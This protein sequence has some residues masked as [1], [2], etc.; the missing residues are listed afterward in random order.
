MTSN[1]ERV[2]HLTLHK[3][4]FD[5]IASGEKPEEYRELKAYWFKRL[6]Y[7][8]EFRKFEY[9]V[10]T[11]GYATDAPRIVVECKGISI[12]EGRSEWGAISG[13]RY[14]VIKL[15]EILPNY[16]MIGEKLT[17]VV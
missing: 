2:L 4:Y 8:G 6:T 14:F 9:I 10:F 5:M 3:R 17:E 12:G 15:G 11:N 1:P 13:E 7:I 16:R